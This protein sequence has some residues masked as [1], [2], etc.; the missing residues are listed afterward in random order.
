MHKIHCEKRDEIRPHTLLGLE[1]TFNPNTPTQEPS[2]Y[3]YHRVFSRYNEKQV[4][5]NGGFHHFYRIHPQG[6]IKDGSL[7]H[8]HSE[9]THPGHAFVVFKQL[10]ASTRR[11]ITNVQNLEASK[12]SF[13]SYRSKLW[14]DKSSPEGKNDDELVKTVVNHSLR[15]LE[16]KTK[17]LLL[18]KACCERINHGEVID[19]TRI[20]HRRKLLCIF[21]MKSW[22]IY[23]VIEVGF[24]YAKRCVE[25][26]RINIAPSLEANKSVIDC[27]RADL[28]AVNEYIPSD[29]GSILRKHTAFWVNDSLRYGYSSSPIDAS[30]MCF[31]P[32]CEWLQQH[33]MMPEK[34]G[35]VEIYRAQDYLDSRGLWGQGGLLLHELSHA[36]HHTVVERGFDNPLVVAVYENAMDKGLYNRVD[37]HGAQGEAGPVKGYAATNHKE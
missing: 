28:K 13:I 12:I 19:L 8:S 2:K 7:S 25:G 34:R 32:S 17:Q 37:V 20:K 24:K 33:R 9:M 21:K 6:A 4:D 15:I 30:G 36:Y 23:S 29:A 26:W 18:V 5:F 3:Q 1:N 11:T 22:R 14:P 35:G 27:L 31:H 16:D 10:P